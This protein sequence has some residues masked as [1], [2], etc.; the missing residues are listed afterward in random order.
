[1]KPTRTFHILR[2]ILNE[3]DSPLRLEPDGHLAAKPEFPSIS[4]TPRC[5]AKRYLAYNIARKREPTKATSTQMRN[6]LVKWTESEWRCRVVNNHGW[7]VYPINVADRDR[8]RRLRSRTIGIISRILMD[9]WPEYGF[10]PT[11]GATATTARKLSFAVSKV[12]GTPLDPRNPEPHKCNLAAK[13]HLHEMFLNNPGVARRYYNARYKLHG[14]LERSELTSDELDDL[15]DWLCENVPPAKLDFVPKDR[16]TVRLIALSNS[17]TIMVQ[18]TFGDVIRKC[19]KKVGVDLNDQ[20]INQQ[21]AEIG[22][23]TDIVA[24]VDLSSAS[25]SIALR[26]LSWFPRRWQEIVMATRDTHVAVGSSIH[27]LEM[28]AGMGNGLI[29][30]LESLL[31][32]AMSLAVVEELGLETSFVSV[33]GDDIIVP[34]GAYSLLEEFFQCFGFV[35]NPTKSYWRGPFRE[36]CGKHY[37]NGFDVSPVFVNGDIDDIQDLYHCFNELSA[38][39]SRTGIPLRKSIEYVGGLIPRK[40]RLYVPDSWGTRTGIKYTIEDG[41]L[42]VRKWSKRYQRWEL[43]YRPLLEGKMD[44]TARLPDHMQLTEWLLSAER[45]ETV[46]PGEVFK[47]LYRCMPPMPRGYFTSDLL[48]PVMS[49]V[50]WESAPKRKQHREAIL[51]GDA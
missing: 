38:W 29:F 4:G 25:D 5:F 50:S 20:T 21:W 18:K 40:E 41:I 1:M 28:I 51:G 34:S 16:D 3:L 31:F 37:Y 24:T 26:H 2:N 22:S 14:D 23:L 7:W 10:N 48:G 44:V 17:L 43:I 35:V 8:M 49:G 42:P 33:Y 19:L 32:Y 46:V 47:Q 39:E 9:E 15:C 13:H 11:S 12:D 6:A 27:K 45:R 30:E 36:S